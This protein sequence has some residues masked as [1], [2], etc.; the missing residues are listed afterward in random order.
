LTR[1]Q[2]ISEFLGSQNTWTSISL[3]IPS[4]IDVV[5]VENGGLQWK[6]ELSCQALLTGK[7]NSLKEG[8]IYN[9][10]IIESEGQFSISS[11]E[12]KLNRGEFPESDRDYGDLSDLLGRWI[13]TNG[14]D[15]G[16]FGPRQDIYDYP[17]KYGPDTLDLEEMRSDFN[18]YN[19]NEGWHVKSSRLSQEGNIFTISFTAGFTRT[20]ASKGAP[21]GPVSRDIILKVR[22][23]GGDMKIFEE[24]E[25]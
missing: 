19:S 23:V 16:G 17:V 11:Y 18:K 21:A 3:E 20:V 6:A 1:D 8:Q 5:E 15:A 10:T 7:Y 25:G 24:R 9:L 4:Q 2:A 22:R 13:E 14:R 12:R